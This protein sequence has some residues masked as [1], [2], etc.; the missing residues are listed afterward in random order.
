MSRFV[1]EMTREV[2]IWVSRVTL[3]RAFWTL[4]YKYSSGEEKG[5]LCIRDTRRNRF[6]FCYVR[7]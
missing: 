1:W 2:V 5:R 3:S 7:S 4:S 6:S